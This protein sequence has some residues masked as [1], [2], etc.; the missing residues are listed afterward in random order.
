MRHPV[1]IAQWHD[2]LVPQLGSFAKS[3]DD[4]PKRPSS[5]VALAAVFLPAFASAL[6]FLA[7]FAIIRPYFRRL[8]SPRT[9]IDSIPEKD[10]TPASATARLAWIKTLWNLGDK[11]VLEH[12]SLDAYL[13]LRFLRTII[14]ICIVGTV[15]TWP[16]LMPINAAGGG[17]AAELDKVG[18]G[19]VHGRKRLYAHAVVAWVFYGFVMFLIARE[20]IWLIGVRQAWH[21]SK[22]NA[23][24]LSSR[25]VLYLD[26][27]TEA[28]QN[29]DVKATFG[30]DAEQQW[31]VVPTSKL[32]A[33]VGIRNSTLQKLESAQT[34]WI[35]KAAKENSKRTRSRSHGGR[36]LNHD[37]V[38]SL[39]PRPRTRHLLGDQVDS[40]TAFRSR[41]TDLVQSVDSLRANY[42][43]EA[44]KGRSAIFVAF[45]D[46]TAAQH[47]YK[48]KPKTVLP[49]PRNL[50]VQ[51]KLIGV[52]PKE[53]LWHNLTMTHPE[54]LSAMSFANSFVIALIVVW[55]I[56]SSII[57]SI[58][59]I[60][61]L[62][63]NV[64][65]LHWL[66]RLPPSVIGIL[67]G[68]VPPLVTSTISSYV[69]IF[70]R[71]IA[72]KSGEPTTVSAELQVQTWYY[73]FQ[74]T[75]VF[76]VTALSSS[77]MTFVPELLQH[78][79]DVPKLLA[80]N[81]P[82]SSN[83][84]VTYFVLQGL[85]FAAKN[86]LNYSDLFQ[87]LFYE[88]FI[89]K[90]PRAKYDQYTSLKGISW[91]KVYPKFTN[92]A[93]IA[94]AYS[95]ISPLVIGFAALGLSLF[96]FSYLY[97]LT[98]VIQ[99]KL[100]TKGKCYTRALQQILTGIYVGELC[101]IGLFG[102]RKATGP[103]VMLVILFV[104]TIIYNIVLN[105]YLNPLEDHLPE[106][107]LRTDT[108]E[109]ESLLAAAEQGEAV[110]D[111]QSRL[112]RIGRDLRVPSQIRDPIAQ[113]FEPHIYASHKAMAVFLGLADE[114][115]NVVEYKQE[116][117]RNA[118]LNP[119]LTS[120]PPTVWL[121]N[122]SHDSGDTAGLGLSKEE[123]RENESVGIK[124]V[125][126]GAWITKN[127][128]V[129]F[130]EDDLRNLPTWKDPVAF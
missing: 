84:Y 58:S 78:P 40:I 51:S 52:T 11:F 5:F 64:G 114:S 77:A 97:N 61:Y 17:D 124:T 88:R 21:L 123:I 81:L 109:N 48:K 28:P 121:P 85:A 32:D 6:L 35:S 72:K 45:R 56:P 25:T 83:F 92:F 19:N 107:L 10:R 63:D 102:L 103:L 105:R 122:D 86:I 2:V 112:Q 89:N 36:H 55:S 20:R 95:C 39:R 100:E 13:Y 113:F 110:S 54:R 68:L 7:I 30:A 38:N 42:S 53:I 22:A 41:A 46:Q 8:Y 74:V 82:S 15:I 3:D 66:D 31:V 79:A 24:R 126:D 93:I 33:T 120:E 94:L 44:K 116:T 1:L 111:E 87:Y 80:D 125:D 37:E 71:Y 119:S 91:G 50:T 98:F 104:G 9:Y 75:Q 34:G 127:G 43:I 27:P 129:K 26:P 70:M 90:T 101:L 76:L 73:L 118:Y 69:P 49:V 23:S 108:E 60:S 16:I 47:A 96:Y 59:N 65:W 128:Q 57:G 115:T 106:K 99:A 117:L 67:T 62:K 4:D 29:E 14:T 18:F 12:S 130:A